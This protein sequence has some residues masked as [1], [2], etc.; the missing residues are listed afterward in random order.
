[1]HTMQCPTTLRPHGYAQLQPPKHIL[2]KTPPST[3][4]LIELVRDIIYRTYHHDNSL[5]LD[6]ITDDCVFIGVGPNVFRG[7]HD[8]RT[9]LGT[10]VRIPAYLVRDARFDVV[11][12]RTP[13]EVTV[14]GTYTIYSEGNAKVISSEAQRITMSM[15]WCHGAWR[16]YVIHISNSWQP[17][18][19]EHNF[20]L[21]VSE[22]TYQYVQ[23]ILHASQRLN[24][25]QERVAIASGSSTIYV[26][27]HVLIYVEANNKSSILHLT[28]EVIEVRQLLATV[29]KLLPAGFVRISRKHI[30]NRAYVLRV[31]SD[32]VELPGNH[33]LPVPKRRLADVRSNLSAPVQ[34]WKST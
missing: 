20:P 13:F 12:T 22:Q 31:S 16:A 3:E 1:M 21:K 34:K 10:I 17:V 25:P 11:P 5:L 33:L 8:I 32:G 29:A 28:N 26:N 2:E 24:A 6:H 19:K 30:V 23:R 27:P 14:V 4:G 15:R 9:R 7:A 18:S